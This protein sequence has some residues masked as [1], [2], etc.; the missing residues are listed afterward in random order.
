M[1]VLKIVYNCYY[2]QSETDVK[3]RY[4]KMWRKVMKI[5]IMH[6]YGIEL[7]AKTENDKELL[8]LFHIKGIRLT[9]YDIVNHKMT[10]EKNLEK[11]ALINIV[12]EK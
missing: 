8:N 5:D 6:D 2:T 4:M 10:I 7:I 9:G 1:Y 3:I 11:R 12:S